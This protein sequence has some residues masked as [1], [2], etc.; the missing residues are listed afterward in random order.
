MSETHGN[1]SLG[2]MYKLLILTIGRDAALAIADKENLSINGK[3]LDRIF[4][5]KDII[6][7][8]NLKLSKEKSAMELVRRFFG[9]SDK[10][11]CP[12][13]KEEIYEFPSLVKSL[14]ISIFF[15]TFPNILMN[16]TPYEMQTKEIALHLLNFFMGYLGKSFHD[17]EKNETHVIS[18]DWVKQ[19]LDINETYQK[20]FDDVYN[21]LNITKT[22][23]YKDTEKFY[24][25][26]PLDDFEQ[27]MKRAITKSCKSNTNKPW[28][29]EKGNW[30]KFK[31]ILD[32]INKS[33]KELA[34]RLIGLYLLKNT[35]IAL[36]E[37]CGI[38]QKD[39]FQIKN[40]I[41]KWANNKL[42]EKYQSETQF[43]LMITGKYDPADLSLLQ[44]HSIDPLYI[45]Q[46][47][48]IREECGRYLWEKK[49]INPIKAEQFIQAME[50]EC[51]ICSIFFGPWARGRLSVL[52]CRFDGSDEDKI[53]QKKALTYYHTA[54]KKGR[55]FAGMFFKSFLEESVAVTVYFNPRRIQDIPKVIDS[56]K[57]LKTPITDDI[58]ESEER[59]AS[60][61][62]KQYYEYGYALNLFE[63]ES[64]ETY[65]LHFHA[66]EHFWKIF[67]ASSFVFHEAAER[68]CNQELLKAKGF[69][70]SEI[71]TDDPKEVKDWVDA[72]KHTKKLL[73]ITEKT[74]N[75][76]FE[77]KTGHNIQYT[78]MSFALMTRQLDIAEHYLNDF[79]N[80]LDVTV[81]N[82][83][84]STALLEALTQYKKCRFFQETEQI[85]ER[86][87]KAIMELIKRSPV[88]SLYAETVKKHICVLEEA[89]NTFDIEIV[90]AIVEK[91]GFDI[92]KLKI[93]ADE[94]TPLYYTVMRLNFI[95]KVLK[96]NRIDTVNRNIN[97]LKLDVAGMFIEDKKSYWNE[98]QAGP[99]YKETESLLLRMF[100]GIESIRKQEYKEIEKIIQYLID[101]TNNVDAFAKEAPNGDRTTVLDI[102]VESDFADICRLLIQKG[103]D[104]ARIF[105][106]NG[107]PYDSPFIRAAWFKSW[108]ALEMLL[109]DFKDKIKH[110]I[111]V[112]F[113]EEQNTAAH[114][115]FRVGNELIYRYEINSDNFKIIEEFIPLFR[116][117]GAD[118]NIPDI[119]NI[120]VHTILRERNFEYLIS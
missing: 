93:S 29:G 17:S 94:L 69:C 39:I 52:S 7:F 13:K 84:G 86:Y 42:T 102:A 19:L 70:L 97:W 81:I 99:L 18:K 120:T 4:E 62:A 8:T 61:G 26:E 50:K 68:V 56:D 108:E 6:S 103:A 53:L 9:L 34:H 101:K 25:G 21:K 14:V 10:N 118:F 109:T 111:N 78:P 77:V 30:Y 91:K 98:T 54:F 113:N 105:T 110:I 67:P 114:M 80:T 32:Y 22:K 85:T 2:Q 16:I 31:A 33:N 95:S 28:I 12:K 79:A 90:K 27:A 46:R 55:K 89:I 107:K 49:S 57:D 76:R 1:L 92:Q 66:E 11:L 23:I 35:E 43:F 47:K 96:N 40:D 65:F 51:P 5:E 82:T 3:D 37:I 73:N 64:S 119:R 60:Y 100:I 36:K 83:H 58:K 63:L 112:R 20:I 117:A 71:N 116:N 41:L 59:E 24:L 104:P 45:K 38:D 74:I 106:H 75:D 15:K 87:K 48:I 88:D 44:E 72:N 115:L